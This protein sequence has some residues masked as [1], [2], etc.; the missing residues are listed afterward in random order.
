E[1]SKDPKLTAPRIYAVVPQRR[2]AFERPRRDFDHTQDPYTCCVQD[3]AVANFRFVLPALPE[4]RLPV[5]IRSSSK[6]HGE[7]LTSLFKV[8]ATCREDKV[9]HDSLPFVLRRWIGASEDGLARS[10]GHAHPAFRRPRSPPSFGWRAC[11]SQIIPS[12]AVV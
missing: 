1:P 5:R 8:P 3:G 9:S 6:P 10:P 11:C 12:P 7:M 2:R 4:L